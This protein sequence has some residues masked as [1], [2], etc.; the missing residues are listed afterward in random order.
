MTH[1]IVNID[2]LLKSL[3]E[4]VKDPANILTKNKEN[5]LTKT[6]QREALT[7]FLTAVALNKS[8]EYQEEVLHFDV[9]KNNEQG[10]S[11]DG[12]LKVTYPE[13]AEMELEFEQVMLT[14]E[15]IKDRDEKSNNSELVIEKIKQKHSK[16][17]DNPKG[18]TLVVFL[19]IE[20]FIIP[21]T[22]K[23]YLKRNNIFLFYL[24]IVLDPQHKSDGSYSYTVMDLNPEREGNHSRFTIK[25]S[26]DFSSYEVTL[27]ERD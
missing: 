16:G 6:K 18:V 26:E 2:D 12:Y 5:P 17:Y 23:A 27:N 13:G 10:D 14:M 22:I 11:L 20:G 4:A 19:D 9:C 8:Y 1:T 3:E 25:I 21:E 15:E 24:L 7:L